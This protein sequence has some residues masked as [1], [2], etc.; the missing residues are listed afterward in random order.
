MSLDRV[1]MET[2]VS[3]FVLWKEFFKWE[4]N[5]HTKQD[6]YLAQIAAEIRKSFVKNPKE[7]K[8]SNFLIK[9]I[10][11]DRKA[12][13]E[14]KIQQSKKYKNSWLAWAGIKRKK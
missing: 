7:V 14:D 2:S 8:D 5:E 6:Y 13:Q 1:K 12:V 9:F 4:V 11:K 3:Q 10:F